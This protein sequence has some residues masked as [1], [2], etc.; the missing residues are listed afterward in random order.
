MNILPVTPKFWNSDKT[1]N[2]SSGKWNFINLILLKQ[3]NGP[4]CT[5]S[6][7]LRLKTLFGWKLIPRLSPSGVSVV[8][9]TLKV[10]VMTCIATL[11]SCPINRRSRGRNYRHKTFIC[12]LKVSAKCHIVIL[13][14]KVPHLFLSS[15]LGACLEWLWA[16]ADNAIVAWLWSD[17]RGQQPQGRHLCRQNEKKK[18]WTVKG[19]FWIG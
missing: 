10:L 19:K 12:T 15:G 8:I 7:S 11:L 1:N 2:A 16:W 18:T 5:F 13:K 4:T 9:I 6:P 3:Q 14:F 17:G